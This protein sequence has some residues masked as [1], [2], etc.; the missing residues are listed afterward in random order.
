MSIK[1]PISRI[2]SVLLMAVFVLGIAPSTTTQ[3]K[4]NITDNAAAAPAGLSS[5]DWKQIKGMLPATVPYTQDAYIKASNT[6]ANDWFGFSIAVSGDTAVVGAIQEDSADT[7]IDGNQADN[8]APESGAVYVFVRNAGVWS[9]QAYIKASNTNASD[10]FGFAVAID[11]DTLVVGAA[12]EASS[13]TGTSGL[14]QSNNAAPDAGAAY[15]FTRTAGVWSQEAYLKASNTEAGDGFGSSVTI[16]GNTIVVGSRYEDSSATSINGNQ[17]NNLAIYAGAAYVFTRSAG[18]WSQQAYIKASNANS[19]DLFSY[20]MALYGDTLAVGAP[21]EASSATGVG[22]NQADNSAASAGAVYI[23]TRSSNVWTQQAYIKASNTGAGDTFGQAVALFSNMLAVGAPGEDSNAITVGGNQ[24]DNSAADAGAAYVFTRSGSAWSQQTYVKASNSETL[25]HFGLP[26]VI[27]GNALVVGSPDEDSAATGINGNQADNTA[28]SS[29]AA[30]VYTHSGSVWTQQAYVKTSNARTNHSLCPPIQTTM[31]L[32]ADTLVI[33][34][35]GEDSNATGI[36]GN[37]AN[38]SASNSGAAYVFH[39]SLGVNTILRANPNPTNASS[40]DFNVTFSAPVTGVDASDFVL[41]TTGDISGAS[42]TGVTGASAAYTVTVNTGTGNGD[43]ELDV[44]DDD[45]IMDASSNKLGGD[46]AGNGDFTSGDIYTVDRTTPAILS[47]ERSD[48]DPTSNTYISYDVIFSE[49]VSG[50][51]ASDFVLN[52]T[53]PTGASVFSVNGSG[54]TRLVTVNRGAGDGTIGLDLPV[55]A[56]ITDLAGNSLNNLP[57]TGDQVYTIDESIPTPTSTP[58]ITATPTITKT[59]TITRTRTKTPTRTKTRT[60]TR[61]PTKTVFKT[62]TKTLT[63]TITRTPTRTLTPTRVVFTKIIR[64]NSAQDGWILESAENGN[65][66]GSMSA[67]AMLLN[68]GDNA[69]K[70]QFRSILSFSTGVNLPD[71]AVITA[72]SLRIKKQAI[73]GGNNPITML[74][75]FMIDMKNGYFGTSANLQLTDFQ[76]VP[77]KIYGPASPVLVSGFY[78]MNLI[79]ARAYINKLATNGG[80]TQIRLR[81][82]LDDNNNGVAN[83]L[84]VYSGNAALADRPQLVIRYYVP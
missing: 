1:K 26:V 65:K 70:K 47:I 16:S 37:Q 18:V 41:S 77:N 32:Y 45:T 30:Y 66:G 7:D 17:T 49:G 54:A 42:I 53:G 67:S 50:V 84:S 3:A 8:T 71:T 56:V 38:T 73:V 14:G 57:Y 29:G 22:G 60:I 12:R 52:T 62:A 74:Q 68:F 10:L 59:P 76:A 39:L 61:T 4:G 80:L 6:G 28:P 63:R 83:Y 58:T 40:V 51:E 19:N 21:G 64:P 33:G 9:Q 35:C 79:N 75:G 20:S 23:F 5:T 78:N 27:S 69:A 25:D 36:N 82:R 34:A 44:T 81:F 72:L 13:A 2:F 55:D 11:G 43:V 24:L 15:V 46:G 48:V 31:A